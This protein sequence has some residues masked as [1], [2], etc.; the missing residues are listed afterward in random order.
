MNGSQRLNFVFNLSI[1]SFSINTHLF[2][3]LLQLGQQTISFP[4]GVL[5]TAQHLKLLLMRLLKIL[6]EL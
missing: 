6:P 4:L 1:I 3:L 2:I 5:Q